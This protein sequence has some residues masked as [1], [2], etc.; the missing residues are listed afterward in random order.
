[1]TVEEAQK[2]ILSHTVP[3]M[4]PESVGLLE[5]WGRV[6]AENI[7]SPDDIPGFTNSSMDG[8]AVLAN[9]LSQASSA[10]PVTLR[11]KGTI[12]A[13]HPSPHSL[14]HGEAYKIMTGAPLPEGAD[15]VIQSEWT[16]ITGENL[17][18]ALSPVHPGQNVRRRGQDIQ[19]GEQVLQAGSV[20]KSPIVG[21][22]ATVGRKNVMVYRKP[23]VAIVATG[24]ELVEPGEELEP[25][26]IRNSNTF[27]LAA[28]SLAAGADPIILPPVPD[29]REMISQRFRQAASADIILSSGGVS[30]GDFD[31][32]KN[33]LSA[34]GSLELWRV[35]MK[36]GKPVA[37]G[38]LH[39]R[40]FFGLPGNPVS[41]L[42]TFELF[43]R[44]VIRMMMAD[45]QWQRTILRLPLYEPF[46]EVHDRR[47]YVRS[48]LVQ[49]GDNLY[50]WPYKKQDS[51][52]QSS[53]IGAE[54]LMVV[55]ENSGPYQPGDLLPV[56]LLTGDVS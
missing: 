22:L 36:P 12:A 47:H 15:A 16:Q 5:A 28:A 4:P 32:V 46:S 39:N 23:T 42:V 13:G 49:D 19:Q 2:R 9:D 34:E 45:D 25:G 51:A 27:A 14:T 48:R 1:M 7:V 24:D 44:P 55:P 43:V 53:W 56:M 41:A 30:I 20:I 18:L 54:A 26:K 38:M 6:L 11:I 10:N 33:V 21:I 31:W 50:I 37:F 35:N 3:I 40:P 29:T 52:V 8:F 17:V